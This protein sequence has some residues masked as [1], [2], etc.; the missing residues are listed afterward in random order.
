MYICFI[1]LLVYLPIDRT[2]RPAALSRLLRG[3]NSEIRTFPYFNVDFK[4]IY[5]G[6]AMLFYKNTFMSTLLRQHLRR[7]MRIGRHSYPRPS[8]WCRKRKWNIVMKGRDAQYGTLF[9]VKLCVLSLHRSRGC[10]PFPFTVPVSVMAVTPLP[11]HPQ[12][13]L[14]LNFAVVMRH[15]L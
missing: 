2:I 9:S 8:V 3:I 5:K 7:G 14:L 13:L 11:P 4:I 6:C 12:P 10:V 15:P 1:Q